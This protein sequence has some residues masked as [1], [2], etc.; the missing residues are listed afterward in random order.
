[1]REERKEEERKDEGETR[2]LPYLICALLMS[3]LP[4]PETGPE[5]GAV[6][7]VTTTLVGAAT[8]APAGAPS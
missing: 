6:E 2:F 5:V 3:T 7:A 4:T 8:T 1:M